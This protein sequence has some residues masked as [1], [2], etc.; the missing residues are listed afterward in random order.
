MTHTIRLALP[1]LFLG[2]L[3]ARAPA[4]D[5]QAMTADLIKSE[6]PGYGGLCGVV[7]DHVSG[8]VFIDLSDRGLYRSSDQ[9][10]T[11]KKHGPVVKGRTEWPG[12]LQF[13]PNSMKPRLLMALVYGS[14]VGVSADTGEHWKFM[15]N[16]SS[17]VD[18]CAVDW[19]DP[20]ANFVLALKHES[21]GLLI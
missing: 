15:D 10:K 11:W 18:W 13:D 6:K 9:G 7:V 21:N 4:A 16:K 1:A 5:W 17:H 2:V 14:P 8:S 19:S 3:A 20:D 12:C